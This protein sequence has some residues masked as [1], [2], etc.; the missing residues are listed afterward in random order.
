MGYS[1]KF[2]DEEGAK[3]D[4]KK[5]IIAGIPSRNP[6]SPIIINPSSNEGKFDGDERS[7][8]PTSKEARIPEKLPCPPAPR[9]PKLSSKFPMNGFKEFFSSP[10]LDA[11]F[12][13]HFKERV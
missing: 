3:Q 4:G 8:T 10:D 13:I 7:R 1:E 2:R 9:K 11:L 5:W 12:T 6:L